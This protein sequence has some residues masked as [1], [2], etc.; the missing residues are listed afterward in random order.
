MPESHKRQCNHFSSV[1]QVIPILDPNYVVKTI[2]DGVLTD[3]NTV[4]IPGWFMWILSLRAL[5]PTETAI[6]YGNV[7][8]VNCSMDEFRGR[9]K[10][11]G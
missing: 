5:M 10:Q 9:D 4:Y 3:T 6:H 11:R 7:L 2:L 8:G 1:F